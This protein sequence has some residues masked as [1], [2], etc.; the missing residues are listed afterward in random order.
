MNSDV[1]VHSGTKR[2]YLHG[3]E[4]TITNGIRVDPNSDACLCLFDRLFVYLVPQAMY[5]G[6][7]LL[8]L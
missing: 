7:T 8:T 1:R 5:M 6:W 2:L 4:R 3:L